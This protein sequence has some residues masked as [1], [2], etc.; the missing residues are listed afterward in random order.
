MIARTILHSFENFDI[1]HPSAVKSKKKRCENVNF[2]HIYQ[3]HQTLALFLFF[4]SKKYQNLSKIHK[5]TPPKGERLVIIVKLFLVL[6]FL[7][8]IVVFV[9]FVVFVGTLLPKRKS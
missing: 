7:V 5:K 3:N 8:V 2:F 6:D 9:Y 1:I 4:S